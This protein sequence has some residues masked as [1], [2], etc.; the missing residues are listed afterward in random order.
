MAY[1]GRVK[2]EEFLPNHPLANGC[3]IFGMKQPDFLRTPSRPQNPNTTL[4][5]QDSEKAEVAQKVS[6]QEVST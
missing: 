6:K 5:Q 1:L 4:A 2:L 3:V